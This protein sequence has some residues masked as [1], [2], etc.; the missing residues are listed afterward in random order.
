MSSTSSGIPLDQAGQ[1]WDV[2]AEV[3]ERFLA[4]WE[5]NG[6]PPTLKD[7]VPASPQTLRRLVQ[8][9]LIKIDLEF[10]WVHRKV[11]LRV[12]D[13]LTDMP[14][15]RE[16]GVPPDLLFDEFHV[17][18]QA[19]DN[20][21]AEEYLKRFPEQ[22]SE[23]ARLFDLDS[24]SSTTTLVNR[25]ELDAL[26]NIGDIEDFSLQMLLG[27]GAFAKVFLA[28]QKS[29][30]RTVALKVSADRGVE[31][32]TLAQLDHPY[33]VRVFDQRQLPE[34]GLRLM[35]MQMVPGGTLQPV[36]SLVR[37]TPAKERTGRLL[38]QAVDQ[39]LE[40]Q[41]PMTPG[42]S[43]YRQRLA[44]MCWPEVVAWV[45]MRLA[46]ALDYAA[47]KGV[48]HR[49]VK[50]A[51]VLL[52][53]DGVP[54]LTDFNVSFSSKVEGA[55]PAAFFGG[56][57]GYMSPEQLDACNP[58]HPLG[59]ETLDHKSDIY[60][61]GIMLWELLTGY[62]PFQEE[63]LEPN[64]A[65]TLWKMAQRRREGVPPG[66]VDLAQKE[67]SASLVDILLQCLAPEPAHRPG[68]E[69]LA[70][71]LAL[72]L[73]PQAQS[74]LCAKPTGWRSWVRRFPLTMLLLF[75]VWPNLAA[76]AFHFLYFHREFIARNPAAEQVFWNVHLAIDVIAFPL[77]I[78]VFVLLAW[79]VSKAVR[80]VIPHD[81]AIRRRCLNLG[82]YGSMI[83]LFAW[84][85]GCI[86]YPVALALALGDLATQDFLH[87]TASL[88]V[89]GL[90]AAVHP[91][92]CATFL[93]LRGLY[94]ALAT[95]EQDADEFTNLS[96]KLNVYLAL[97]A[98]IPMLAVLLM[99]IFDS[100]RVSLGIM[101]GAALLGFG[102]AWVL[103]REMT[104]DLKALAYGLQSTQQ[105]MEGEGWRP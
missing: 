58:S 50:P 47:S 15:L 90:F 16:G 22:A 76:A 28:W 6:E 80:G 20:V 83:S 45:G 12:E 27:Q 53:A 33:I 18:K 24:Y 25:K 73:E 13:Y 42:P 30:Q 88:A 5:A 2:V 39:Q 54:K 60:S 85:V 64:W 63:N 9:E 59:P 62:R 103:Y 44:H 100:D 89:C 51:N 102:F 70:R 78:A 92:F 3:A 23:L 10:R 29:M 84:L 82:W 35:Y 77:G 14:D 46:H 71:Q 75:G 68:G 17:R 31:P 48:L 69:E 32:Q 79:P 34:R 93:A 41:S 72:C 40:K 11:G 96:R 86:I 65:Q 52:S 1:T 98:L 101:A 87:F 55:T 19:G 74:L 67:G 49:D 66:V 43:I 105:M 61:L 7:Y 94:P 97:S 36:V 57:L 91:F 95:K 99:A 4:A 56:S 37:K 104:A 8:V 21:A 26:E 81:P 38:L